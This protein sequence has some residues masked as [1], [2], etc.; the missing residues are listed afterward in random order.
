[1]KIL[2][3][4]FFIAL[5][6]SG[7]FLMGYVILAS[8]GLILS[9][10]PG[11][12]IGGISRWCERISDSIFREPVN[13]LSNLGFMVAGLTMLYVLTNDLNKKNNHFSSLNSISVL[14]AGAA[15]Y[16]GPGSLLMH[17]THTEWGQWADNLSMVMYII[18]PWLYNLKEMGRWSSERFLVT[19]IS[20]VVLYAYSRWVYG[21]D[22]GIGL[23]L[24]GLS[25]ALWVISEALF[26]YWSPLFRWASGLVGF[27][28]A[29]VFGIFPSE[30]LSN[31]EEFWWVVLFWLPA[32]FAAK[33]PRI[34]RTYNPWFYLGVISYTTA[35]TIWLNQWSE[36]LCNPDSWI[37][38]HA[39]W[40]L[41]SAVST[42]C[43]FKFFRTEKQINVE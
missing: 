34:K 20:I 35:F 42:W 33:R 16:L 4:S 17:G 29:A 7:I 15:I 28:V 30:M 21:D 14:Y 18:F 3:K 43:F 19:Y 31:I 1:M 2:E 27:I 9:V 40:H 39:I 6:L 10:E 41:L 11:L 36:L 22:L 24:F 5:F 26:R 38:P 13:A 25:I 23:D 32:V 37:Q 8:Q 12:S